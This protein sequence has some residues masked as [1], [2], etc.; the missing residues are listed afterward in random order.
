MPESG[1]PY[2]AFAHQAGA[3]PPEAMKDSHAETREQ[4]KQCALAV[5]FGMGAEGFAERIG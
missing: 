3:V 4:F 2:L 1:D 5:L